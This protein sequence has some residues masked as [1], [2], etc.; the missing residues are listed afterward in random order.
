[1]CLLATATILL[2]CKLH[3]RLRDVIPELVSP[4]IYKHN[5]G[6]LTYQLNYQPD[7]GLNNGGPAHMMGAGPSSELY[8]QR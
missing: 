6:H 1:M 8:L 7:W 5:H 3:M 2:V 4:T